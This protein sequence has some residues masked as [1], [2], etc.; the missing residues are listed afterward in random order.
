M[1]TCTDFCQKWH[2]QIA[3]SFVQREFSGYRTHERRHYGIDQR[4]FQSKSQEK[5]VDQIPITIENIH[6]A[7]SI[8][9]HFKRRR[10]CQ[11]WEAIPVQIPRQIDHPAKTTAASFAPRQN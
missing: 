2:S 9:N 8:I 4:E 6:S 1:S 3:L 5:T 10:N 11:I 7:D